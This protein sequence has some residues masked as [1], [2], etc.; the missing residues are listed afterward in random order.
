MSYWP[1]CRE[2]RRSKK[3]AAPEGA[4]MVVSGAGGQLHVTCAV[5]VCCWI[6]ES[7]T[8]TNP[9]PVVP[10]PTHVTTNVAGVL[11]I[12]VGPGTADR[13]PAVLMLNE[14]VPPVIRNVN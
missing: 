6:F 3:K 1:C 9:V 14:G 5:A 4:A 11:L 2:D 8:I 10:G 13:L 12:I 7:V